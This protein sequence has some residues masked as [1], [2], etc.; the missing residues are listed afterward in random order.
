MYSKGFDVF[1]GCHFPVNTGPLLMTQKANGLHV[2]FSFVLSAYQSMSC[3]SAWE[4]V[5][6]RDTTSK[7]DVLPWM[8]Y[9][10]LWFIA[11]VII[12]EAY[13]LSSVRTPA[14]PP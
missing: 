3:R 2:I 13:A 9:D 14:A 7:A 6:S 4:D 12:S 10:A 5:R 11:L 1:M 8:Q